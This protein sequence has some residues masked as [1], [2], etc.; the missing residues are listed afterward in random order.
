[1][2]IDRWPASWLADSRG[3]CRMAPRRRPGRRPTLGAAGLRAA[4]ACDRGR[5]AEYRDAPHVRSSDLGL[6][7]SY[8]HHEVGKDHSVDGPIWDDSVSSEGRYVA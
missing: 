5:D 2:R 1:M 3:L 6:N 4:V 7:S 8:D